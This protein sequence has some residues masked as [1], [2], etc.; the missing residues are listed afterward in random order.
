MYKT[1]HVLACISVY[2]YF[3]IDLDFIF[4]KHIY[5]PCYCIFYCNG[6]RGYLIYTMNSLKSDVPFL[7]PQKM[8]ENQRF[9]GVFRGFRNGKLG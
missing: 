7:Y 8:S 3:D 9:S 2:S 6:S 5:L 1:S 4:I